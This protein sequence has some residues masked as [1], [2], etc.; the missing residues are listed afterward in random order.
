M[1]QEARRITTD[2]YAFEVFFGAKSRE[3]TSIFLDDEASRRLDA[4][5]LL[6][7]LDPSRLSEYDRLQ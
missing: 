2:D 3:L 7:N 6:S 1:I 5:L 4:Y